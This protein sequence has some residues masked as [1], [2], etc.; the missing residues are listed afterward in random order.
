MK[1][2][3]LEHPRVASVK[4]FNDIANTPL[5]SCLMGGYA[6]AALEAAGFETVFLDQAG[7]GCT[8][9]Q[10]TEH[11]EAISP[12]LLAVNAVY[13]WEHTPQLFEFFNTLKVK[14]F[15]GHI[16]LFGFF[17]TL[18][19]KQILVQAAS[20]DSIAVGEFENTLV[21][22]AGTLKKGNAPSDIP[23][24]ALKTEIR[25]AGTIFKSPVKNPDAFAFPVRSSLA[26][27][28]TVL[29]SRGC[30]NQ[31]SFC[32]VP[33]FYNKGALWRGRSVENVVHEIEQL[34]DLGVRDFY[35]A[36]ANFIGPGRRGKQRTIEL[37]QAIQPFNIRFGMETRPQDLDDEI[38]SHLK[39]S[40]FE[41]LLMG[42]ESGSGRI[43]DAMN[44]QS[45]PS[46]AGRAI[47]LCRKYDIEPE[48]GFLMFVPDSTVDDLKH[49]FDFLMENALLDRLDRTA[50]LLCHSQ[51]VLAGT[52]G[53]RQF[54][55]LGQLN[56][57]GLFGFEGDVRFLDPNV[58]SICDRIVFACHTVLRLMSDRQSPIYWE[59]PHS[60]ISLSLNQYLISLFLS[61]ITKGCKKDRTKNRV[62]E[63]SM[64]LEEI[65]CLTSVESLAG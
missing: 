43:L 15:T 38:M 9:D 17:P 26:G 23:G 60:Q 59:N 47:A 62:G 33:P 27:T 56:K 52:S 65:N 7:P 57:S 3:V 36:D 1:A 64:I 11:L 28:V 51:I 32:P 41:S 42:V 40:G 37:M 14:G 30:Y 49:N 44:K 5:W 24:L 19:Y 4:R 13:F 45:G 10:V 12:D 54:D 35:F 53:Y 6:A 18:V 22:L 48:I 46:R 8:F 31:C 34:V 29:A 25:T 2:C 61:L 20:V 39:A 55:A 16:N 21:E 63:K 50:N 58:A